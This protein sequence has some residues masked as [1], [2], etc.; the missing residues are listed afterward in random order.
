M[1]PTAAYAPA[2]GADLLPAGV[3]LSTVS[4]PPVSALAHAMTAE[5]RVLDELVT[6]IQRQRSAVVR[7]DLQALDDS[8]FATRRVLGTLEEARRRRRALAQVLTDCADVS[9]TDLERS[10]G[11]RMTAELR[12]ASDALLA[13]AARLAR[14]VA[15]NRQVHSVILLPSLSVKEPI[16]SITRS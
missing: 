13:S 6:V 10:L 11:A 14:E 1:I 12:E 15:L 4:R 9:V 7:D 2:R 16:T 5:Q 3:C 8:L